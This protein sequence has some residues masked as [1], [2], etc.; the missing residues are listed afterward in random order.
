MTR[1]QCSMCGARTHDTGSLEV[2]GATYVTCATCGSARLAEYPGDTSLLYGS[3]YFDAGDNGGY[4]GYDEDAPLHR[5]VANRRLGRLKD[6]IGPH[7]PLRLLDVGAASGYVLE[8]AQARGWT[9]V[10]VDVSAAARERA[11]SRGLTVVAD[12]VEG[13]AR[14]GD[15]VDVVT[16]YQVLEHMPDPAASIDV[17]AQCLA[18]RGVVCIETWDFASV[19]ARVFGKRWQQANPP[20]VIHLPTRRGLTRLLNRHGLHV[21]SL[22]ITPKV[23]SARLIAGV[24][25]QAWPAIGAAMVRAV[26]AARLERFPVPYALDDL[27]TVVAARA[28]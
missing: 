26:A 18:P 6:W 28:A 11:E 23:V 12:F 2:R 16:A 22:R 15:E 17:V 25:A 27:V 20:S 4:V 7:E 3:G 1:M 14:L 10:G 8:A 24:A 21:L 13:M 5:R 19:T 9:A